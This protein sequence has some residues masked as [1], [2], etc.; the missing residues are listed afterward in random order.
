MILREC[1]II[2]GMES[3]VIVLGLAVLGL[4][5]GSFAGASVW[6]LRVRQ[7]VEDKA[8][9]EVVD[10][11]ELKRLRRIEKK[12]I[13][14]DRSVCLHCGHKLAWY[15]LLPVFSWLQLQGKC[16]YCGR[17]IGWFE[18]LIE[19]GTATFFVVSYLSWPYGLTSMADIALFGLW[20]VAGVGLIVLLSYD[21]KWFLLPNRVMFPVIGIAA[22][23]A[24]IHIITSS[25]PLEVA[26]SVMWSCMI[27]SGLYFV[28]YIV[29]RGEWIGFGDIKLGLALGL[30]LADWK[31]ALLALFMANLIGTAIAL[32]ALVTRKMGRNSRIPFGPMLILGWVL[33]GLYGNAIIEWYLGI[34]LV[35]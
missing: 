12:S 17:F 31:L 13:S 6:R 7:L 32:P 25:S 29:S 33:A 15:D 19:L 1:C 8:D 2:R 3:S 22:I 30:L 34:S 4:L 14:E 16:R 24:G 5:L 26:L 18:L 9:G 21:T 27:L 28:L 23:S 35:L 11:K 20:L 10:A